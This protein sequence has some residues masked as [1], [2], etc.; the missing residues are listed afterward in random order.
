MFFFTYNVQRNREKYVYSIFVR[1]EVFLK[2]NK[3]V[4]HLYM[5]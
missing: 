2:T 1:A 5:L 4:A 3:Y